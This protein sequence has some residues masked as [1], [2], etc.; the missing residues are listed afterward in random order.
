MGENEILKTYLKANDHLRL[1]MFLEYPFM[2]TT[3][4]DNEMIIKRQGMLDGKGDSKLK[5]KVFKY[6][7]MG[8]GGGAL[9]L[10]LCFLV[11]G[12]IFEVMQFQATLF[13]ALIINAILSFLFFAQHS[14]MARQTI[15][16]IIVGKTGEKY[17]EAI[18][19]ISSGI[20]LILV[21]VLWQGTTIL[22]DNGT[23]V[24]VLLY[25]LFGMSLWGM[26]WGF[27][28]LKF[29][30]PMGIRALSGKKKI[31][32]PSLLVKGPYRFVRHPLYFFALVMFWASP[33]ITADRLLFNILW[34]GWLFAGCLLEEK[35]LLRVF[36]KDYERYQS[37]VP[38][39]I[40]Y[41]SPVKAKF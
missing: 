1:S 40:P 16:D 19:S 35:D 38:M 34:S 29:V 39:L 9:F 31:E 32:N 25:S 8:I 17:G 23:L 36:G 22:L 3:F 28:S 20:I 4:I 10:F 15:R 2:R 27:R 6:L 7:S 26:L 33:D 41:K 18:F 37:K 14:I 21:V 24:S 30:D 5:E 11:F 12:P 13:E